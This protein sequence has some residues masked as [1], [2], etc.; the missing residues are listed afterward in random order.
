MRVLVTTGPQ[1]RKAAMAA[2]TLLR[3]TLLTNKASL[4]IL[5]SPTSSS[6]R[7]TEVNDKQRH[8]FS[9]TRTITMPVQSHFLDTS[10]E[11]DPVWVHTEPYSKRPQFNA[12]AEYV[13]TDVCVV[14][15]GIAGTSVSYELVQR[16]LKVVMLEAREI[17]SGESGDYF[18]LSSNLI[19]AE[20]IVG[21]GAPAVIFPPVLTL[22]SSNW[23]TNAVKMER[24]LPL[25][26]TPTPSTVSAR[27][28]KNLALTANIASYQAMTFRSTK[29]VKT[30]M[31]TT[32][33]R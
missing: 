4:W 31:M 15:S 5:L 32:S 7:I 2:S 24:R 18:P 14:G 1:W 30:V 9:T 21:K 13:K 26:A 3:R 33:K 22:V 29:K 23:R 28:Q 10:G 11:T 12:L 8:E 20:L 17:L 25:T 6:I 27:S 19:I 16:G